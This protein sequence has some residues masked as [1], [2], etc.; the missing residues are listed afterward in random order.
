MP[1]GIHHGVLGCGRPTGSGSIDAVL[2]PSG[3]QFKFATIIEHH[4]FFVRASVVAGSCPPD[5]SSRGIV[6]AL[7]TCK[8]TRGSFVRPSFN[9]DPMKFPA[10]S[11]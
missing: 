1:R 4:S 5:G 6:L 2:A 11:A 10:R 9:A 7:C 3:E 8:R